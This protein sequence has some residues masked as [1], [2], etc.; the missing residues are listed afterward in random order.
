MRKFSKKNNKKIGGDCSLIKSQFS[1]VNSL[2]GPEGAENKVINELTKTLEGAN[3]YIE[4]FLQVKI[5]KLREIFNS[6]TDRKTQIKEMITQLE[7][8]LKEVEQENTNCYDILKVDPKGEEFA[9]KIA[10][11]KMKELYGENI[12]EYNKAQIDYLYDLIKDNPVVGDTPSDASSLVDSEENID[13]NQDIGELE[14]EQNES[15]NAPEWQKKQSE[16]ML[17]SHDKRFE[18][19][20][21]NLMS[22]VKNFLRRTKGS[23]P[24]KK[25]IRETVLPALQ[26]AQSIEE[27]QQIINDNQLTLM[28]ANM[29]GGKS[30]RINTLRKYRSRKL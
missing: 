10:D 29:G 17:K 4:N 13:L 1:K 2:L 20:Y 28:K 7:N 9:I 6:N 27:V 8:K 25:L 19:N 3:N 26:N 11:A 22:D 18:M 15:S 14:E 21:F 24:R 12:D 16:I 23:E 30:K 5:K